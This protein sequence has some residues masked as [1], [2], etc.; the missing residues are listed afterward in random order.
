MQNPARK[1]TSLN[2]RLLISKKE[3][4][5]KRSRNVKL[6]QPQQYS[7]RRGYRDVVAPSDNSSEFDL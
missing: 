1:A 2:T 3:K 6:K 5:Q 4:S 7:G